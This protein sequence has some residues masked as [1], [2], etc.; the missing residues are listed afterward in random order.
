MPH[1]TPS[2]CSTSTRTTR[3]RGRCSTSRGR[4]VSRASDVLFSDD[5]TRRSDDEILAEHGNV[6]LRKAKLDDAMRRLGAMPN[7]AYPP[8]IF[9]SYKWESES[10]RNDAA[11]LADAL[12]AA[13]WDVVIDRD[14]DVARHRTV[15]E[16]VARLVT[17]R[18]FLALATPAYVVNAIYPPEHDP[19]WVFDECQSAMLGELRMHR[20]ALTPDGVLRVPEA[21]TEAF[22]ISRTQRETD[23][24]QPFAPPG[25]YIEDASPPVF[26]EIVQMPHRDS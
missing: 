15:E 19:S 3:R 22:R 14:F 5:G 25:V 11:A 13:G 16:F 24:P 9:L 7:V 12:M 17:C 21:Q 4:D 1:T 18:I 8:R 20:I 2:A 23:A 10:H 6:A 26:D